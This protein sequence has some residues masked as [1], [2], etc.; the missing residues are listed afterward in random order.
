MRRLSLL[1]LLPLLT[2][3]APSAANAI[4][5]VKLEDG[6]RFAFSGYAQPYFRIVENPCQQTL[7]EGTEAA[8]GKP[9]CT[10]SIIPDGFGLQ[11]VRLVFEGENP[12]RGKLNLEIATSPNVEL[13]E[14]DVGFD[15]T[16]NTVLRVGRM[17]VPYSR[18]GLVSESRTQFAVRTD[19]STLATGRQLGAAL[20]QT[21]DLGGIA[22]F[23]SLEI[24][25]FNGEQEAERSAINNI[26]EEFLYT[27][28]LVLQPTGKLKKLYEGDLRPIGERNKL[29]AA[30]GLGA[31]TEINANQDYEQIRAG[32]DL[33]LLYGGMSLLAESLYVE[34]TFTADVDIDYSGLGWAVAA[35]AFVPGRW[36]EEHL[37]I[38]A[39]YEWFDP[40]AA[41]NPDEAA[42]IRSQVAG[43]GY[44]SPSGQATQARSILTT[45]ANIYFAGHDFK[46]QLNYVRRT[47]LE[48]W[49]KSVP[50]PTLKF[51]LPAS[52]EVDDDSFVAQLTY[53]L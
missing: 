8:P 46:L 47:E 43:S 32:A 52:R 6:T 40:K 28:R 38:A 27:A 17:K 15:L 37:E 12:G 11:H 19:Q 18:G 53:R 25:A 29:H 24:G 51:A 49:A 31:T 9:T 14:M 34:R 30:L 26:D 50:D 21:L 35:G 42:G 13:V 48:D 20:R 4:D 1:T 23:A 36:T 3:L 33:N 16:P 41:A 44:A 5:V 45:G 2:L 22:E 7:T 39:R 10:R